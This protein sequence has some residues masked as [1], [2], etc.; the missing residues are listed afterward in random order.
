MGKGPVGFDGPNVNLYEKNTSSIRIKH[1][2]RGQELFLASGQ[3][4]LRQCFT[5]VFSV[6]HLSE[7]M[8]FLV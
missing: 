2:N 3:R 6:R 8:L 4:I 5:H 1:I 7:R